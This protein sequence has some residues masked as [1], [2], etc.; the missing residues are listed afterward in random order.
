MTFKCL[1]GL[2][3][4]DQTIVVNGDTFA[5]N[6]NQGLKAAT[7]DV[8]IICNNDI[9]FTQEDWLEQLL[10]PLNE[11][12]DIASIRT[13]DGDGW[14]TVDYISEGDYFGSIWAMKRKVYDT[15]GGFDDQF[16]SF[17]DKDYYNR[18]KEAGFRIGKNHAGLV[19]HIG[20][21]TAKI[22]F[23][24]NE[25]NTASKQLYYKKYGRVD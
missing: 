13:T 15:I 3:D 8:I 6:V 16:D 12:F 24:D 17:E 1:E 11:G 22:K 10:K 21:A 25:D 14:D 23:P 19:K 20:R 9:E 5:K 18:A 4:I 7:G 2:I